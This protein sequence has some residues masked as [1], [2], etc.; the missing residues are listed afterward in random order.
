MGPFIF[1]T[2]RLLVRQ[3]ASTDLP[4]F[5]ALQGNA[6]V[7]RYTTVIPQTPEE[8]A[9]D[10]AVIIARYESAD[11]GIWVWAVTTKANVFVG[12]CA[13]FKNEAQESEI[14]YR[15]LESCWDQGYGQEI[16]NGLINYCLDELALETVVAH[17]AKDNLASVKILD[18]S[19][20]AFTSEFD[21]N[22]KGW[23][24]RNY[25]YMATG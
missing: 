21:N 9:R 18:R 4:A 2:D 6:N 13:L 12:T 19:R 10:L 17:A 20:L 7:M 5:E 1:Q 3:L 23:I 8:S 16:A 24:E 22:E 15:L 25:K 11:N 14:A